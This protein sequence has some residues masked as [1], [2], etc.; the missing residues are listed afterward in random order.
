MV[1]V[2]YALVARL[3]MRWPVLRRVLEVRPILL[4]LR[5]EVIVG[6]LRREGLDEEI[7]QEALREHGVM[8]LIE[9]TMAVLEIDWAISVVPLGWTTKRVRRSLK[10]LRR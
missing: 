5:S 4:V 2:F 9:I 8:D 10:N 3:S 1:L 7:L 6:H